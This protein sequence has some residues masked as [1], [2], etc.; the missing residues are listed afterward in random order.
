VGLD[1]KYKFHLIVFHVFMSKI[2]SKMANDAT[3]K[4]I[5]L[6]DRKEDYG[7]KDRTFGMGEGQR[8]K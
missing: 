5:V 8:G 3:K 6:P 7:S 1:D 2:L 4:I